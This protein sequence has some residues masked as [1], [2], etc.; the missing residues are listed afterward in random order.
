M[1]VS[2]SI[3]VYSVCLS[4]RICMY[5]CAGLYVFCGLVKE[6]SQIR[7]NSELVVTRLLAGTPFMLQQM[8]FCV[9]YFPRVA[10]ET[11]QHLSAEAIPCRPVCCCARCRVTCRLN[12]LQP[13]QRLIKEP[14]GP[15]SLELL[16]YCHQ[17]WAAKVV[18]AGL[19]GKGGGWAG[20]WRRVPR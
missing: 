19:G 14:G 17:G 7:N 2:E 4:I 8:D 18:R 9:K 13:S 5:R 16:G 10:I 3:C 11:C 12:H 1:R 20:G 6:S 15:W